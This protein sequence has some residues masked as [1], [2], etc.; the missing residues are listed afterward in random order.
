LTESRDATC[1]IARLR[2]PW[3]ASL[4]SGA[5][6]EIGLSS[7][8]WNWKFPAVPYCNGNVPFSEIC[9]AG[10]TRFFGLEAAF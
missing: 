8:I 10:T 4:I 9:E 7:N 6:A 5:R 3:N 1:E 2:T